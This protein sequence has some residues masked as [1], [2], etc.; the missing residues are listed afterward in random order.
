ME[1]ARASGARH[2]TFAPNDV[3]ALRDALD[4]PLSSYRVDTAPGQPIG[5]AELVTSVLV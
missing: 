3:E 4:R 1:A 5:I 2:L